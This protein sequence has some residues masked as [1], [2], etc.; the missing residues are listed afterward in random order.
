M[1]ISAIRYSFR[2]AFRSFWRHFGITVASITTVAISLLILGFTLLVVLNS[3]YIAAFMESQ[4]E[5]NLFLQQDISRQDAQAFE[6]NLTKIEGVESVEFIPKEDALKI[7]EDGYGT[8]VD[9]TKALGG[10]NPLPDTYRVKVLD[11]EVVPQVAAVIEKYE[12]VESLRYGQDLVNRLINFT[13]WLRNAGFVVI[14]GILFA[15][16]FLITTT[17]RLT[18]FARKKEI[19]IMK[20][21]GATN[22]FIRAPFFLEGMM[23]GLIGALTAVVIL[24]LVYGTVVNYAIGSIPFMPLV[25]DKNLL[26]QIFG[27][28]LLGGTVLGAMGSMI[29]VRKYLNV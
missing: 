29:A 17:I 4:V 15:S 23:I 14:A 19:N 5:I 8:D 1:R 2:D 26:Y 6:S 21:V 9:I 12:E 16:L 27:Y 20:Y 3:Q 10:T 13:Q 24:Y 22:S 28:L 11:V 25:T 7:M 18:V